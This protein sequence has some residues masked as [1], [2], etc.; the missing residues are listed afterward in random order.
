MRVLYVILFLLVLLAT[1]FFIYTLLSFSIDSTKP[2]PFTVFQE[3]RELQGYWKL[4]QFLLEDETG[5][6]KVIRQSVPG[7]TDN[8]F[9]FEGKHV[10]TD[11]Q[12]DL[13]NKPLRCQNYTT[14]T[15]DGNTIS[16]D[17]PGKLPSK[18]IWTLTSDI[19][20]LNVVDENQKKGKFILRRLPKN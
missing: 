15:V 12:L 18:T 2:S 14:Y 17:Q 19:L 8:Y 16:I 7:A 5:N 10:C 1:G 11:G 3:G 6:L 20:E 9:S 4:E 13:N